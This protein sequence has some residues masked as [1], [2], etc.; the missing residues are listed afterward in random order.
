M[1]VCRLQG[2]SSVVVNFYWGLESGVCIWQ[3]KLGSAERNRRHTNVHITESYRW[4][5]EMLD[6][7]KS[8][9]FEALLNLPKFDQNPR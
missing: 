6:I 9:G 7:S 2:V 1:S 8:F 3:E 5:L 4:F